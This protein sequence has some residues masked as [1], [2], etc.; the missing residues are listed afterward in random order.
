LTQTGDAFL[1]MRHWGKGLVFVNGHNL[2]RYW[3]IGP[4]QTLYVP[5]VWLKKGRNEIVVFEQ[6]KDDVHSVA[7]ISSPILDQLTKDENAPSRGPMKEPVL[8]SASPVK[9][10]SLVAGRDAQE[11]LFPAQTA[12]YLCLQ[13]LSSQDGDEYTTLAELD[14]LDA[15]GQ[16]IS[17]QGWKI[18]YVDSEE[19]FAEGDLA[20]NAIDGDPDSFWH[21]LWSAPHTSHPHTLV[22]DLGSARELSGLRLLPRQDSPH[23][24]IKDYRLY[25]SLT[26]F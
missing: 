15:A 22:V 23:G 12:R 13:A 6:L 2:G 14:A 7:G 16:T 25:L 9:T 24:R 17:H 5:G 1:D 20:E 4:Q 10:G 21:T 8:S 11:V 26:P 18:L 3:Y 19:N